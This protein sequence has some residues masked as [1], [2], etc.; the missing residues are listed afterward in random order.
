MQKLNISNIANEDESTKS[1]NLII[2]DNFRQFEIY[3][4]NSG[5]FQDGL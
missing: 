2:D 3:F 1:G 5:I 4:L